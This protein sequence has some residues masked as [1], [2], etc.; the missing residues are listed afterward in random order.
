MLELGIQV[1]GRMVSTPLILMISIVKFI[2]MK[3]SFFNK[4]R[5]DFLTNSTSFS[6]IIELY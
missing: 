1:Q 6:S 5:E 2:F 4:V 3:L